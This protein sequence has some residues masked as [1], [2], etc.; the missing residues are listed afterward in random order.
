[1]KKMI[2]PLIT[3]LELKFP[4][5]IIGVGCSYDQEDISRPNGFLHY[6]WIQSNSGSGELIIDGNLYQVSENQGMLLLPNTA[7]EYHSVTILWEVDWII[8]GGVFVE[9][10]FKSTVGINKS[11]VY[12]ISQPNLILSK[13]RRVFENEQLKGA[14]K[15]L[16]S[17]RI[18]YD[19]MI[20]ILKLSTNQ[21]NSNNVKQYKRIKPLLNFIEENYNKELTLNTLSDVA[22]ITPQ[23]LCSLFKKITGHRIFE[24]INLLRIKKSKEMILE[25][26]DMQIKEIARFVGFNDMSYFG[27]IFK[28][29]EHMS[30]NEFRK[31]HVNN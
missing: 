1:M 8:F 24:Y 3:E 31:L 27:V 25:R 10:F 13:I 16:E 2:F 19:I 5:Y 21:D 12:S 9:N 14:F 11:A 22:G 30:P 20:D 7:H 6:Q 23:H 28:R 15:S 29:I 26:K 18:A 17:S 4:Y